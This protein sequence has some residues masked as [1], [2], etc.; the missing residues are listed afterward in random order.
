MSKKILDDEEWKQKISEIQIPKEDIDRLILEYL[1][2]EGYKECVDSYQRE[3][4]SQVELKFTSLDERASICQSIHE[5]K[6]DETIDKVKKLA[7]EM[8]QNETNLLFSLQLQK[9]IEIV[10]AGNIDLAI[11]FAQNELAFFGEMSGKYLEEIER[12]MSLVVFDLTEKHSNSD[13]LN[14]NQRYKIASE[15]NSKI[16]SNTSHSDD[17]K[18]TTLMKMLRWAQERLETK[19]VF[20]KLD[21]EE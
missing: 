7:P 16:L 19:F 6:I 20:P 21:F 10:R 14:V 9:F 5:G 12:A 8:L 2:R 3:S 15:L 11:E 18:L 13:L 17:N 1:I 4:N